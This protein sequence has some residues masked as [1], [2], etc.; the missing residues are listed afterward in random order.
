MDQQSIIYDDL[1]I[2]RSNYLQDFHSFSKAVH[3]KASEMVDILKTANSISFLL[4]NLPA[5]TEDLSFVNKQMDEVYS[6]V[7]ENVETQDL[8]AV[9]TKLRKLASQVEAIARQRAQN[10]L[11]KTNGA[12]DKAIVHSQYK[13]LRESFNRYVGALDILHP[14]HGIEKLPPMPGNYAPN[15]ELT[16]KV[17]QFDGDEDFYRDYRSVARRLG[18]E[19]YRELTLMDVVEYI[20]S[21]DTG[22]TISEVQP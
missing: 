18:L 3:E 2:D 7:D 15:Q 8:N 19:N 14:G 9:A 20:N 21:N 12:Y 10:E 1:G 13:A 16:Y 5:P 11:A 6:W 22:V 4:N 17:F